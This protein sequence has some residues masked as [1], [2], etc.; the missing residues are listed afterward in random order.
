MTYEEFKRECEANGL[1][2]VTEDEFK[3]HSPDAGSGKNWSL[4]TAMRRVRNA[5]RGV[6]RAAETTTLVGYP[7]GGREFVPADGSKS[8]KQFLP[9]LVPKQ[10]VVELDYEGEYPGTHGVRTELRYEESH[11]PKKD[12][13]GE[14]LN[15]TVRE[16]IMG[17][18][19]L[20]ID[21]LRAH[22]TDIDAI[23]ESDLKKPVILIGK[24][25]DTWYY[26]RT[27]NEEGK[28]D[29]DWPVEVGGW[30]VLQF[31]LVAGKVNTLKCRFTPR[32]LSKPL[33]AFPGFTELAHSIADK[34]GD[35]GEMAVSFAEADVI[36]AGVVSRFEQSRRGEGN[37]VQVMVTGLWE[38]PPVPAQAKLGEPAQ[39]KKAPKP[40][41][42]KNVVDAD[43]EA[44][45]LN[46]AAA[47]EHPVSPATEPT[48]D[49][50]S[51]VAPAPAPA[52][53]PAPAPAAAPASTLAAPSA[54]SGMKERMDALRAGVRKAA[55]A[56]GGLE[57]V[58]VA[59]A[60][61]LNK[62]SWVWNPS[63]HTID[64]AIKKEKGAL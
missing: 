34:K 28:P 10:G 45:K 58:T 44:A 62:D 3:A 46:A 31:G 47:A 9:I 61:E 48:V 41:P 57:K 43:V 23:K 22:A 13:S 16:T 42:T 29:G 38:I 25:S 15:R 33:I 7:L 1:A 59:N 49:K 20:T 37:F 56:L 40:A 64:I 12:G 4:M 53:T 39:T 19:K 5:R 52:P 32:E 30:P 8:W 17:T 36:V 27:F 50:A 2:G 63:E 35:I 26:E 14:W 54:P 51:T 21:M 24:M 6:G 11:K 18:E 60:R 55:N